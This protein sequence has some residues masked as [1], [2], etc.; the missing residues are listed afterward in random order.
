MNTR[1]SESE[2]GHG[3]E[4]HYGAYHVGE[5]VTKTIRHGLSLDPKCALYVQDKLEYALIEGLHELYNSRSREHLDHILDVARMI[6]EYFLQGW[7][8]CV[9][10]HPSPQRT[11]LSYLRIAIR[12]GNENCENSR[13]S[14]RV[15]L[16]DDDIGSLPIVDIDIDSAGRWT[17]TQTI[18]ML[19]HEMVHGYL[20]LF[21][22]RGGFSQE[23]G[24]CGWHSLDRRGRHG[25][26]V[27]MLM[28]H[29]F[30]TIREWNDI[31]GCFGED[32]IG[33]CNQEDQGDALMSMRNLFL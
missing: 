8:T 3:P 29:I 32:F 26:F 12:D 30:D 20:L 6:D 5:L 19:I 27:R 28:R 15:E 7:L 16:R 23:F 14:F 10:R 31:L 13:S 11:R 2:A 24:D 4:G 9:Q 33:R 17:I 22:C 1:S 18:E 25:H 21:S